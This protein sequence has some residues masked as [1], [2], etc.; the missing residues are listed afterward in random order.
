MNM[1]WQEKSIWFSLIST[2]LVFGLYFSQAFQMVKHTEIPNAAFIV[3]FVITIVVVVILQIAG[4]TILAIFHRKDAERGEDERDKL[5]ELRATRIS[6]FI[7]VLG[8][9]M[10][11]MSM[12][13]GSTPVMM[14]NIIMFFFILSEVVCFVAQLIY[15]R[16]GV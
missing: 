8:V 13:F 7:L 16:R 12:V 9:W 6:Y 1:S 10:T 5:I 3:L 4:Q 15:Y 11:G 2:I 14:A